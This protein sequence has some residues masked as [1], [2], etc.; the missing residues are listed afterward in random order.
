MSSPAILLQVGKRVAL[1]AA[2]AYMKRNALLLMIPV[3]LLVAA[4]A[5]TDPMAPMVPGAMTDSEVAA[6]VQTANEGEVMHGQAASTRATNAEVRAFAQ[7][8][9]TDHSNANEQLRNFLSTNNMTASETGASSALR[10]N[11]QRSLTAL[12]SYNGAA[13]DREYMNSQVA[14][15][16]WV[17]NSLDNTLIPSTRNAGLRTWLQGQRA[18]VATHLDRARR[19]QSGL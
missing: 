11:A 13:F 18:A 3:A 15:H 17:L 7:M 19:I 10:D 2:E 16:Q 14:M 4:C 6:V 9:V 12:N 1:L 8:M 5:S